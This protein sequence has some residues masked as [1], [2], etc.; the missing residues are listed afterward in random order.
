MFLTL[1]YI[2]SSYNASNWKE[3]KLSFYLASGK[4][5]VPFIFYSTYFYIIKSAYKKVK[6]YNR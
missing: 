1:F 3:Y 4:Y 5:K 2:H 6:Q